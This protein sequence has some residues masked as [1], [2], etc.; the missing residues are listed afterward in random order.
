MTSVKRRKADVVEQH[1]HAGCIDRLKKASPFR[2]FQN[3]L[4]VIAVYRVCPDDGPTSLRRPF[5]RHASTLNIFFLA[6]SAKAQLAK[7]TLRSC[8]GTPGFIADIG[9]K[10]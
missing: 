9:R 7:R 8:F 1:I 2:N 10:V 5:D 4:T 3:Q 6:S